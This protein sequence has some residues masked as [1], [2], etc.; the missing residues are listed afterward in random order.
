[1]AEDSVSAACGLDA[2]EQAASGSPK[3]KLTTPGFVS[4]TSAQNASS[5]G[6]PHARRD[7]RRRV[8]A[9]LPI[10]GR[11]PLAPARLACV[12]QLR[13]RVTEEIEID[14]RLRAGAELAYLLARLVGRRASRTATSQARLPR[15]TATASS[16]SMAPAIGASRIGSSIWNRSI[17]RRSGHMATLLRCTAMSC[18]RRRRCRDRDRVVHHAGTMM[19]SP[20]RSSRHEL[21]GLRTVQMIGL[22]ALRNLSIADLTRLR[23]RTD[24]R[25]APGDDERSAMVHCQ[26]AVLSP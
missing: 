4:S 15:A 22:R 9:K 18:R 12:A 5:N 16:K 11:E 3:W 1:M 10:I 25:W 21:V 23:M 14:L 2:L 20:S 19:P 7:R 6:M 26:L 17:R 8:D 13:R 24:A